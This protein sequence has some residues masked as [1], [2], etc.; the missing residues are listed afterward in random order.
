MP[1]SLASDPDLTDQEQMSSQ[2][3]RTTLNVPRSKAKDI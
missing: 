1:Q 2:D 3:G